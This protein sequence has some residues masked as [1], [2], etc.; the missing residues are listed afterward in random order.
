[1]CTVPCV[2]L[3][4]GTS[5]LSSTRSAPCCC[6]AAGAGPPGASSRTFC[7]GAAFPPS[8][9]EPLSQAMF[10]EQQCACHTVGLSAACEPNVHMDLATLELMFRMDLM[11]LLQRL[12]TQRRDG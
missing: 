5:A 9:P 8:S 10:L 1:M 7:S 12:K 3:L 2:G 11:H 6:G 4:G